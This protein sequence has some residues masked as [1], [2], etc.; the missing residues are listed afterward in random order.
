MHWAAEDCLVCCAQDA[1]EQDQSRAE[2]RIAKAAEAATRSSAAA[3]LK[4]QQQHIPVKED[5]FLPD[6]E[7]GTG[8][9]RPAW[10]PAAF[11]MCP[12]C[13]SKCTLQQEMLHC[14]DLLCYLRT[15]RCSSCMCESARGKLMSQYL[16]LRQ[17]C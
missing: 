15:V 17:V 10:K 9:M 6:D 13:T 4:K 12:T 7:L 1:E 5:Y 11:L 3:L 2:E 14:T 8:E 16:C